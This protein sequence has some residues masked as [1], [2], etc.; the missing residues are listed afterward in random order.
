MNIM[1]IAF[2]L[3][4]SAALAIPGTAVAYN[5]QFSAEFGF[6]TG[7]ATAG[8]TDLDANMRQFAI[9]YTR[10]FS[11]IETTS[12]P[13][14]VRE[15]LQHP[16]W[17]SAGLD[18][19]R[20]VIESKTTNQSIRFVQGEIGA[21]GMHYLDSGTGIGGALKTYP[22]STNY[23]N[24]PFAVNKVHSGTALTF[25]MHQYLTNEVRVGADFSKGS[26]KTE[27]SDSGVLLE[28]YD[29]T[30]LFAYVGALVNEFFYIRAGMGIGEQDYEGGDKTDLDRF[31][32]T[33]GVF[34]SQ[35]FGVFLTHEVETEDDPSEESTTT[36][37][38]IAGEYFFNDRM[39][40]EGSLGTFKM[41]NGLD[42]DATTLVLSFSILY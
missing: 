9:K 16:S 3:A 22:G 33:A 28:E 11:G 17:L 14:S 21:S 23:E 26:F 8:G 38:A 29:E 7:D 31:S 27:E 5:N 34:P 20:L 37:T 6:G 41:E 4:L 19:K 25:T 40:L 18:Y 30:M 42:V 36:T 13:Y 15:F 32:L 1:R 39:S 35:Q 24:V 2:I 10:F 12:S